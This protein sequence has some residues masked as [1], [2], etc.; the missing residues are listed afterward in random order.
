[1]RISNST[2]AAAEFVSCRLKA[3]V[4][5]VDFLRHVHA[6]QASLKQYPGYVS[7]EL[8]HDVHQDTWFDLVRWSD[9]QAAEHAA[10]TFM[11][12][13]HAA[14][15]IGCLDPAGLAMHHY[16]WREELGAVSARNPIDTPSGCVELLQYR[17]LAGASLPNYEDVLREMSETL[18]THAGF[19]RREVY[20]IAKTG[21]WLETIFYRDRASADAMF[22]EIKDA[23]CMKACMELLDETTLTMT[24]AVPVEF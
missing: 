3:G 2:A 9:L 10:E 16:N 22:A 21:Q 4:D 7:R 12:H 15:L 13:P 1:M 24:F 20:Y 8:Y 18:R 19:I 11:D 14:G 23:P 6:S 17:L 5:R